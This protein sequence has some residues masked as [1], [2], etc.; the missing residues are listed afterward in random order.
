M[1]ILRTILIFTLAITTICVQTMESP[2]EVALSNATE[3]ALMCVPDDVLLHIFSYCPIHYYIENPE[4]ETSLDTDKE[5]QALIQSMYFFLQTRETCKRFH[6]FLTLKTIGN[7]C[8]STYSQSDKD[9][10]FKHLEKKTKRYIPLGTILIHADTNLNTNPDFID[11]SVCTKNTELIEIFLKHPDLD[12]PFFFY[13]NTIEQAQ[14]FIDKGINIHK[15]DK[16]G[17][18]VLWHII[19][20]IDIPAELVELYLQHNV[21]AA[22]LY[23][24]TTIDHFDELEIDPMGESCLLHMCAKE[25]YFEF[26][27]NSTI[28]TTKKTLLLLNSIPHMINQLNKAEQTPLDV[29]YKSLEKQLEQQLKYENKNRLEPSIKF[30]TDLAKLFRKHG[31]LTAQELKQ[32]K[33]ILCKK[34]T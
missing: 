6:T 2:A 4:I 16:K 23:P 24:E 10:W 13:A 14:S 27:E 3:C 28:N 22:T 5:K 11:Y 7:F 20:H 25:Y 9:Y 12:T 33:L 32:K 19:N 26:Y 17:L 1:F 29:A 18:N 21:N 8:K 31:G 30:Y 15:T 34:I